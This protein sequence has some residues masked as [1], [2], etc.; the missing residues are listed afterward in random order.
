MT[1]SS[2][3]GFA[4]VQGGDTRRSWTWEIR[5]VNGR[6]REIRCR[7]ANGCE[8]IEADVRDRVSR[9]FQRGNISLTLTVASEHKGGEVLVN[10]AVLD[11]VIAL[12]P[13]LRERFPDAAPP[14]LDGLLGI[15]GILET[16]EEVPGEEEEE[17]F[18][19]AV[20]R[21]L[22]AAIG[23][24]AENRA[25]EG[26][27]LSTIVAGHLD[28]IAGLT[29]RAS[30]TA[31]TQPGALFEKLRAQVTALLE[32][33]PALSE[34][35]LVQEAALLAAKAD[36]REELDRLAAHVEAGRELLASSGAVGRKLDFLC[37]E[38]NREA[39]TLCSKSSDV[40]L[41]RIGLE[42]KTI[43]DQLREQVQNIE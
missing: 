20:L 24:L 29:V 27:R 7:L 3:T 21:D 41:T 38:F 4:R 13:E 37:Q 23:S 1:I 32:S 9:R 33:A 25:A 40:A 30:E 17:S 31:A 43:I 34:D 18:A 2:M 15:R 28:G 5:S 19:E 22:D 12:L 36:V 39:N 26:E 11:Q 10:R 6:G 35:R 8:R 16:V 14:R 42:L